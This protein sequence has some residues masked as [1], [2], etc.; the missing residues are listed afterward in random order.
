MSTF[1]DFIKLG[2]EIGLDG[3][4]LLDFAREREAA[5]RDERAEARAIEKLRLEMDEKASEDA[6]QIELAKI[7]A[8]N[9]ASQRAL[10]LEKAKLQWQ[11]EV[12]ADGVHAGVSEISKVLRTDRPKL[13]A[14][15]VRRDNIDAY[16]A[17][18]ERF[19][20]SQK[21]PEREWSVNLSALLTGRA[22][23]TYCRLSPKD[24][25]CYK[26]LKLALLKTFECTEEGFRQKFRSVRLEQGETYPQFGA[27]LEHMFTRWVELSGSIMTFDGLKDLL[28]REQLMSVSN[29]DLTTFVKE[30]QPTTFDNMIK[31]AEAYREARP[32]QLRKP[33]EQMTT[34]TQGSTPLQETK[35]NPTQQT[36]VPNASYA[37]LR[38]IRCHRCKQIGHIA[39]ECVVKTRPK[40]ANEGSCLYAGN[41]NEIVLGQKTTLPNMPVTNGLVSG[42]VVTVLRDS[43]CSG[44]VVRKG[45]VPEE[46]WTGEY[47]ECLL[48]DRSVCKVPMAE[49]NVD[50]P[51]YTGIVRVMAM[52]NPLYDLVIGNIPGA[53]GPNDPDKDWK[54]PS[55]NDVCAVETRGQKLRKTKPFTP[56][57]TPDCPASEASPS[58]I[59]KAQEEDPTLGKLRSMCKEGSIKTTPRGT[60]KY[61]VENQLLFRVFTHKP[62]GKQVRQLVVPK[63]Y[64]NDVMKVGHETLFA[65]HLGSRKTADRI[66]SSFYW[67]G[68]QAD[69]RRYCRSCDICQ[70]TVSKGRT[71]K[72]PLGEMPLIDVPFQRVAV[73]I[74]G[75]IH[76]VTEKGNRYILTIVD[77]A[78]RYPEAV[79]LPGIEAERVAEA[80]VEVFSRV[81]IP[82]EVL[83]DRGTQFTSG[84][85]AEVSRLLSLKQLV[86]TPYHPQCNGLVEKFNGTLKEML[87]KMCAEK[88]KTWD[89]YLSAV[90]FAYREAPQESLGFAPFELLYGRTVRGPVTILKELWTKETPETEVRSTYQYVLNLRNRLEETCKLAKEAL[91]KSARRYK[92]NFD[93]KTRNRSFVKGDKVLVL[94]P[95]DRNK[96]LMQWKGPYVVLEKVGINDYRL[97]LPGQTK[98]FHANLLR[99]YLERKE[100]E[101]STSKTNETCSTAVGVVSIEGDEELEMGKL[102]ITL[103]SLTETE[104]YK[105]V[106]V[107]KDLGEDQIGQAQGIMKDF[108]GVLTDL[109][110][111]TDLIEHKIKLL[112]QKPIRQRMYP[113]PYAMRETIIDEV[114]TM[115]KL[116]VIEKSQSPYSSPIV[117]VKKKD[118]TNRFCVDFRRLNNVTEFD[119]EPS[120][121]TDE[122]YAEIGR[123]K[124]AYY[125]KIDM[126]KGYWQ[127]PLSE[128]AKPVTAFQTPLGQFHWKTMP[129]GLVNSA[130]TFTRMM[131]I[132]LHNVDPGVMNYIDDILVCSRTW[133]EHLISLRDVFGRMRKANLTAKPSKCLI[134]FT[135]LEFLGHNI[136]EGKLSP[137]QGKLNKMLAITTPRSKK[138]VRA[139]L[140]L[141]SYYR[142]FI[143]N[144]AAITAPLTDLIRN[145]RPNQ[146]VWDESCQKALSSVKQRLATSPVLQLPDFTKEFIV[147]TDASDEG[148]GAVLLQEHDGQVF[149]V[150]YASRK[151]Q[152]RE[153]NY[154]TTEKECLAIVWAIQKFQRYLYGKDFVLET[155]HEAL[156]YMHKAKMENSRVM[157]WSLAL[158]Q[159]RFTIRSIKGKENI[160]A[161]LLSR[162][163]P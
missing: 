32:K 87:K 48:I 101:K 140:G 71:M 12:G 52:D 134:G 50:T 13:P 39:R 73:D 9:E 125:S 68:I 155:D 26:T 139:L 46:A 109:P 143:P 6:K 83:T 102:D 118:G 113:V 15:D 111:R 14:F 162:C 74:V 75:P 67:P 33:A 103:P 121:N 5:E 137:E 10:D 117:I 122:L 47:Q 54:Y 105:D 37:G 34:S 35:A 90:L 84:V 19:A 127:I 63:K 76:P 51:Y 1:Q 28:L 79:A 146:V 88:P 132:L 55:T 147:R 49:L 53:R 66:M 36:S 3:R 142:K 124:Y 60:V 38:Q 56:L 7:D 22:L 42:K 119:A 61:I 129:F 156:T 128:D 95:T 58:E 91:A 108:A 23:D 159:Y 106:R 27:R 69:V 89:R 72:V 151:L 77:Y 138:E 65:G 78:T 4:E 97:Q 136:G 40:N 157:R 158:Q 126:T 110:G 115:M 130:A 133:E 41:Q 96:L 59:A 31:L 86:T 135:K 149:P 44:V 104:T 145:G 123:G 25:N 94:L 107:N 8:E 16:L 161:D 18:F 81:G 45:L 160:G 43:G 85:M 30:R 120:P 92:K 29:R 154:C 20:E 153:K 163:S 152:P 2:Q 116:D 64:R 112:D 141:V 11:A 131:R 21:W 100:D 93:R 82:N 62:D 114:N 24:A 150:M 80:L 148:L 70:R 99:K 144:F 17:R 98:L 57:S